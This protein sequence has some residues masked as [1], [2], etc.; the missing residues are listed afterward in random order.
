MSDDFYFVQ[1]KRS[2]EWVCLINTNEHTNHCSWSEISWKVGGKE[3]GMEMREQNEFMLS[4]YSIIIPFCS[5]HSQA[6]TTQSLDIGM[7]T[8]NDKNEW[9]KEKRTN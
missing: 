5:L 1:N 9:W 4:F 8:K 2:G 6:A 3:S 7:I